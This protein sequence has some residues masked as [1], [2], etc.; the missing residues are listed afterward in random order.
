M[1]QAPANVQAA[2]SATAASNEEDG[3][4]EAIT[5]FIRPRIDQ[6]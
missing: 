3:V 1:G 4:A 2:A 5:R 6:G